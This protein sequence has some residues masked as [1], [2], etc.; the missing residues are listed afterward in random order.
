MNSKEENHGLEVDLAG[1]NDLVQVEVGIEI[2]GVHILEEEEVIQEKALKQP[3]LSAATSVTFRS[4]QRPASLY[5]A[6]TVSKKAVILRQEL[7]THQNN[8][9][10]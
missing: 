8:S 10:K 1:Q 6:G 2:L 5:I 7:L 3:A 9:I 4:N